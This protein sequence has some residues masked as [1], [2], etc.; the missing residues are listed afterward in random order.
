M[1]DGGAVWDEV[2]GGATRKAAKLRRA[3]KS[4][5][6]GSAA[7]HLSRRRVQIIESLADQFVEARKAQTVAK[8]AASHPMAPYLVKA[9][10]LLNCLENCALANE[11]PDL[12]QLARDTLATVLPLLDP[13]PMVS[14]Y[15]L[16]Q[17]YRPFTEGP[18]T[19]IDER[20]IRYW[21][22][23]DAVPGADGK[24]DAAAGYIG[25]LDR[26][27]R[28]GAD[29]AAVEHA[30]ND[31]RDAVEAEPPKHAIA[32]ITDTYDMLQKLNMIG[33]VRG[34]F[35]QE[36]YDVI[37]AE[38]N[39]G[40]LLWMDSF[41]LTVGAKFDSI[42]RAVFTRAVW[43]EFRTL[44]DSIYYDWSGTDY[45][46]ELTFMCPARTAAGVGTKFDLLEVYKFMNTSDFLCT[47]KP[48][49][50]VGAPS[51]SL[52]PRDDA[53]YNRDGWTL[54]RLCK[55]SPDTCAKYTESLRAVNLAEQHRQDAAKARL[56][57]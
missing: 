55:I 17:P 21:D 56:A 41:R 51:G 53:L 19:L 1:A 40:M 14:I 27:S 39:A 22:G 25:Y 11:D 2:L 34:I 4:A 8:D 35:P 23:R 6:G 32:K 29:Y 9:Y 18:S 36:T 47:P 12:K 50:A 52:D 30:V 37:K 10:A 49:S 43:T 15:L 46:R 31:V 7:P 33:G 28:L 42:C 54:A 26:A 16:L 38:E 57:M 45:R 5:V 20:L 3:R 44:V 24:V 48:V 13:N